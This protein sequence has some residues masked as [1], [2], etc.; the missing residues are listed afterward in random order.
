M[1]TPVYSFLSLTESSEYTSTDEQLAA[2]LAEDGKVVPGTPEFDAEMEK[3]R[4]RMAKYKKDKL[5]PLLP[6]WEVFCFYPMNKRRGT[7]G[8]NWYALP[9]DE[10]KKLMGG[11][12]RVGRKYSGKILQL[13]TGATG[14]D[15]WEWGVTL[16]A[17]DTFEVKAIV[18]EMRFDP[19]T[20]NYGEFGEFYIGLSVP[21]DELFRRIQL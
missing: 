2:D 9:F 6:L 19:V 21:L 4:A 11:H 12:A 16:F 14:L 10:R 7:D 20:A 8:Q 13:I 3:I 5:Y 18:Y 1:L 17:H 15:D